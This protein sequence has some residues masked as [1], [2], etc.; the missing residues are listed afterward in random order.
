MKAHGVTL[1]PMGRPGGAR[2][3][4]WPLHGGVEHHKI[5]GRSVRE[6]ER[7]ELLMGSGTRKIPLKTAPQG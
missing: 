7:F 4:R 2:R 3:M 5:L 1:R 6:R